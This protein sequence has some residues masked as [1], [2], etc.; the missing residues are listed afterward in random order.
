MNLEVVEIA[1]QG[2]A[3]RQIEEP[4][5]S[6]LW[7][8]ASCH[9]MK[10]WR[11]ETSQCHVWVA[12]LTAGAAEFSRLFNTLSPSERE[13]AGRFHFE[14]DRNTYVQ[15]HGILRSL[16]GFYLETKPEMLSF[17]ASIFG[18]PYLS[19]PFDHLDLRFNLSHSN[20]MALFA[21]TRSHDVGV[22]IEH[23]HRLSDWE[24]VAEMMFSPCERAELAA[25]SPEHRLIAFFNG[26]TRKEAVLKATGEGIASGMKQIQVSLTPALPCRLVGCQGGALH[27]TEWSLRH[28]DPA[29]DFVGAVAV[30]QP[31]IHFKLETWQHG[32]C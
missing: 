15:S 23:L 14:K 4:P 6:T 9:T 1:P 32:G 27:G 17:S 5:R 24:P 19:R 12:P 11:L 10:D 30:A 16:L 28:L 31:D 7:K 20:G 8:A 13:R 3:V 21:F 29:P 2:L 25:L 26:W 18:K 22:D